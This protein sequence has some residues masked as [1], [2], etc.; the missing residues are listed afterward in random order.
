LEPRHGRRYCG[1][2]AIQLGFTRYQYS[3]DPYIG[4]PC[5][6]CKTFVEAGDAYV[7]THPLR[8][9]GSVDRSLVSNPLV[10]PVRVEQSTAVPTVVKPSIVSPSIISKINNTSNSSINSSLFGYLYYNYIS[11]DFRSLKFSTLTTFD[12]YNIYFTRHISS[13]VDSY[14]LVL[15]SSTE[16]RCYHFTLDS[17][18]VPSSYLVSHFNLVIA[19]AE[20]SV[21]RS[22]LS[23]P[24]FVLRK[25]QFELIRLECV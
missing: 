8:S 3:N 12:S 22:L 16:V 7:Y 17:S 5:F 13:E 6:N 20:D 21:F 18:P 11:L 15:E 23:L 19:L 25:D 2:C 4:T 9:L 24:S 14:R 10:L 1:T